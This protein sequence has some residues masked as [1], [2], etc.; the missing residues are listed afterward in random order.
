[1]TI[2]ELLA[3]ASACGTD[4][5]L[6]VP[7]SWGQGRTVLGGLSVAL[8]FRVVQDQLPQ[9]RPL[10]SLNVSFVGP[11]ATDQ[12][13]SFATSVLRSGK[14]VTHIEARV[15]QEG[16][17]CVTLLASFGEARD[18]TTRHPTIFPA[19]GH[20]LGRRGFPIQRCQNITPWRLYAF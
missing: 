5:A 20:D 12:N 18:S 19:S 7:D 13:F 1:M 16:Q 4:G 11:L 6:S 14:S 10:R 8:T 3:A 17:V 15:I 9:P 2:D